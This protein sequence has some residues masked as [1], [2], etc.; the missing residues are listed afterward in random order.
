MVVQRI[1]AA[2]LAVPE[3]ASWPEIVELIERPV[4]EESIPCW[5]QPLLACRAVGGAEAQALPGATAIF[6]L[7]YSIHLADDLLDCDPRGLQHVHGEGRVANYALA[8]QAASSIAIERAGLAAEC[9][10][11]IHERLA[12]AALATAYGQSLDSSELRG[13]DEYWKVVEAKT[14]PL[15]AAALAIGG[16][17]GAA[18]PETIESLDRLGFLLGKSVQISDDLKDAF[19]K[20]AA[21]DWQRRYNN[22]PILYAMTADHSEKER[23]LDLLSSIE[24]EESLEAAQEIL[25]T[26]GAVSFC[27]YHMID[28][29]RSARAILA[30][31]QLVDPEPLLMLIERYIKPLRNLLETV[32]IESPEELLT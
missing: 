21:P 13:E 27:A 23:F 4:D 30:E 31:T 9:R 20:P 32:G 10:A 14:P 12:G 11:A 7:L 6:C 1:R 2:L 18:T 19:D 25:V 29:H 24:Q 22:L 8:L 26:S 17:L 5:E 16:M 15:F 3:L 28:L